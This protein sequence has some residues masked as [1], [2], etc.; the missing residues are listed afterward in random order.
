MTGYCSASGRADLA[1]TALACEALYG[2]P[3]RIDFVRFTPL[4]R[5]GEAV[6]GSKLPWNHPVTGRE[7]F[8]WDSGPCTMLEKLTAL[9]KT[10]NLTDVEALLQRVKDEMRRV[11]TDGAVRAVLHVD[12]LAVGRVEEAGRLHQCV[13]PYRGV[14]MAYLEVLTPH[15]MRDPDLRAML[16]ASGDEMFGVYGHC[17]EAFKAFLQFYRP[18]KYGGAL[19]F[20]LKELVRLHIATLNTCH[21]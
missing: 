5:L 17:P 21:R 4:G 15:A 16:Q 7:V 13:S 2:L 10:V 18:L 6:T 8:N 11:L 20:A 14:I 9:G 3:T 1:A 19:P 12:V